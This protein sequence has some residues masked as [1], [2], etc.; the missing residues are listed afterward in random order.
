[1][2]LQ[3]VMK[4][5][6]HCDAY[7]TFVGRELHY[8]TNTTVGSVGSLISSSHDVLF[9]TH[10]RYRT[11]VRSR[12]IIKN[13]VKMKLQHFQIDHHATFVHYKLVAYR[14]KRINE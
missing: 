3:S 10:E 9:I 4:F 12:I 13:I 2:Y 6:N 1:M 7:V 8:G 14:I 11:E 5:G